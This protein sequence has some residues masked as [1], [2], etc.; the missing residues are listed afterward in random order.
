[1]LAQTFPYEPINQTNIDVG[2][3]KGRYLYTVAKTEKANGRC[4]DDDD[5]QT[6]Q[7]RKCLGSHRV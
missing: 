2:L 4:S 3:P 6:V 7:P 1:M 5:D